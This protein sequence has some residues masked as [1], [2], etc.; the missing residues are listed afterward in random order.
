MIPSYL[1]LVSER[2]SS[3]NKTKGKRK[4]WQAFT[5][6]VS[7]HSN[8]ES[9]VS[10]R[11]SFFNE[12]QSI[13]SFTKCGLGDSLQTIGFRSPKTWNDETPWRIRGLC[14]GPGC[15]ELRFPQQ[16]WSQAESWRMSPHMKC[17]L[18]FIGGGGFLGWVRSQKNSLELNQWLKFI[19]FLIFF[20]SSQ[21]GLCG[22]KPNQFIKDMRK[23]QWEGRALKKR[24]P[25]SPRFS[26][27]TPKAHSDT[28][29]NYVSQIGVSYWTP[30]LT[31]SW[32][33]LLTLKQQ[34]QENQGKTKIFPQLFY[35][36]PHQ[37][38]KLGNRVRG[39]IQIITA[40]GLFSSWVSQFA[41]QGQIF[42]KFDL[43]G[44][45]FFPW[46]TIVSQNM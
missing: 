6:P 2:S 4:I 12:H 30:V 23:E 42:G 9:L 29:E 38:K 39:F 13:L 46:L 25:P 41:H 33:D 36:C 7:D 8:C 10:M 27:L 31:C 16:G 22:R 18:G 15:H 43:L 35:S 28:N 14:I 11:D 44:A 45:L 1:R 26:D 5:G 40:L 24:V 32:W 21:S 3:V 20:H 19:S 34:T 37:K 17:H